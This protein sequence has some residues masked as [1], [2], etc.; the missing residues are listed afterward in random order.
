MQKYEKMPDTIDEHIRS[1][2]HELQNLLKSHAALRKENGRLKQQLKVAEEQNSHWLDNARLLQ[3]KIHIMQA[4]AGKME[5]EDKKEFEK[6]INRY[7]KTIDQCLN[8]L[9][10]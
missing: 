7:I 6:T 1:L 2:Q 3:Q 9:N 4:T 5:G 10:Q 8:V